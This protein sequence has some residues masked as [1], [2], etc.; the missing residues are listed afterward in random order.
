MNC[1]P[2]HR[3]GL[4]QNLFQVFLP[5]AGPILPS[6]VCCLTS[7]RD[8]ATR[9]TA[10]HVG[11]TSRDS[12]RQLLGCHTQDWRFSMFI[13]LPHQYYLYNTTYT[14]PSAIHHH[15]GFL[16]RLSS[17]QWGSTRI[18]WLPGSRQNSSLRREASICKFAT[19]EKGVQVWGSNLTN[20]RPCKLE[21]SKLATSTHRQAGL[22][23]ARAS[24]TVYSLGGAGPQSHAVLV[25]VKTTEIR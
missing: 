19:S 8:V 14:I 2:K 1:S 16:R 15:C 17:R 5:P 22:S 9:Y 7:S 4:K 10:L 23:E 24:H 6:F 12:H 21:A 20:F 3:L 11:V 18:H 13:D 25:R